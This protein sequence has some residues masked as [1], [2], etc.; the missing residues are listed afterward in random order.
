MNKSLLEYYGTN[1]DKEILIVTFGG[2]NLRSTCGLPPFEF[3]NC[4]TN[5][6]PSIDKKFFIDSHQCWYQRGIKGIST[7][8][9]DTKVYLEKVIDGY[10]E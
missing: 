5:W 9:E 4:L 7:N 2:S 6:F 10:K 8:I 3:K 1:N